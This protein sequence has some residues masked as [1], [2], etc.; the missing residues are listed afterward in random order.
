VRRAGMLGIAWDD[1][2]ATSLFLVAYEFSLA[3][4]AWYAVS[5]L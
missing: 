4:G 5:A 2:H 1:G 3:F